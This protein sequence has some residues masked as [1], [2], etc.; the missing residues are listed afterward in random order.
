MNPHFI[1]NVLGSIQNFMLSNDSKK[2][3]GYLS[4]FASLT[5]TTL[6]YSSEES[7]A[8][9][10]E[11]AMLKNYMELEQMRKPGIFDFEIEYDDELEADFIQIPPMMI[12]PFIENAIKHGFK[13]IN[14]VGNLFLSFR[15]KM[16]FIEVVIHDNGTGIQKDMNSGK[17]HRSMAMDIF[18]KRRKL[19][20]HKFNKD[21]NFELI[22]LTQSNSTETGVRV[23]LTIPVLNND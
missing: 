21:F 12:Q 7:I 10:D 9:S 17:Q 14:Y 20:Q 22:N 19:I 11:I 8:L 3:A 1:F 23:T 18:E 16:E 13:D 15:D 5:R 6:E 4:K 2:A